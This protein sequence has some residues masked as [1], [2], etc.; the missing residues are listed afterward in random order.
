MGV[1]RLSCFAGSW[2]SWTLLLFILTT[3]T[4]SS[5]DLSTWA[6]RVAVYTSKTPQSH[7]RWYTK[8]SHPPARHNQYKPKNG[9]RKCHSPRT[10]RSGIIVG[11]IQSD[12][13]N[14]C[15][16]GAPTIGRVVVLVSFFPRSFDGMVLTRTSLRWRKAK[17][18]REANSQGGL[19]RID[20]EAIPM[21]YHR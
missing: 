14:R 3:T 7:S 15:C 17:K 16:L 13:H 21:G 6:D 12:D 1:Y 4:T 11:Q 2:T 5:E 8:R 18:A 10:P 19:E 9:L 20:S